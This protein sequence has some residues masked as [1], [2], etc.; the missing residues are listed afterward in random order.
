M[1]L[2]ITQIRQE[3]SSNLR[4][5]LP[6]IASQT[7][8]SISGFVGTAMVAHLGQ[9]ELAASV[10]VS[11]LWFTLS[12]LF[13]GILNAVSVSVSHDF[14]AKNFE[15]INRFMG[16]A[17]VIGILMCILML[18]ILWLM[19]YLLTYS[20]QPPNVL[21]QATRYIHALMWTVPSLLYLVITEQFLGGIGKAK[22]VMV[23]SIIIVPLEIATIYMLMFGK[24]GLS[25][26]GIAALGYGFALSY[27][28]TCV[29]LTLY[30]VLVKNYKEFKIYR[31]INQFDLSGFKELIR[32][33]LPM[34]FAQAIEVSSFAVLTLW[35]GHFGT[36]ML[37]AHQ[38]VLQFLG[39]IVTLLFAMAQ[40][41]TVRI[42]HLAGAGEYKSL[43]MTVGVGLGA[44]FVM[45]LLIVIGF[46]VFHLSLLSIDL[47]VQDP[48][49]SLLIKDALGLLSIVALWLII[50]NFRIVA[51]G[52]L[53]G[54][55]DTFSLLMIA[56]LNFWIVGLPMAYLVSFVFDFG[57][58]GLWW[59]FIV[60]IL[61]GA[62]AMMYRLS[63]LLSAK[64][65]EQLV[66][67]LII[68]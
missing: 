52:A 5:S 63:Q 26:F 59:G 21:Y 54:L 7:I 57:G 22:V 45:I 33:G 35:M 65:H 41:V 64:Y 4:L 18:A 39:F 43:K 68:A 17:Y 53:R 40:A 36:T 55:K 16:Q 38:I 12:I 31:Y 19:P 10:L 42:G 51:Q 28:A 58:E 30:I 37:A 3:L 13:F 61:V 34:G 56:I 47:N 44:S 1:N 23:T 20:H 46:S 29:G 11:M 27:F 32:I 24:L 50:E 62:I 67:R 9:V 8:Y 15:G 14:G 6:F 2:N 60:G 49:N 48:K 25:H 66:A